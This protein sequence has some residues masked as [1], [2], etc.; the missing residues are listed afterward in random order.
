MPSL[1]TIFLFVRSVGLGK[2]VNILRYSRLLNRLDSAY[3]KAIHLSS[4]Q[5]PGNLTGFSQQANT[6][7]LH[8]DHADLEI[9]ILASNLARLTWQPGALP[10]PYAIAASNWPTTIPSLENTPDGLVVR[11]PELQ[12][13]VLAGGALTFLDAQ[14][15]RLRSERPP[16]YQSALPG[17]PSLGQTQWTSRAAFDGEECL[18]G[19]GEHTGPLSLAGQSHLLWNSD[20][21]GSHGPQT[22]PLYMPLPVYLALCP[23][24]GYLLFFENSFRAEFN[25]ASR[26]NPDEVTASFAGGALRYYLIAG[27][28]ARALTTFSQLT[29]RPALPPSWS[30]GYHQSRWG[31]TCEEDIRAVVAS[32][33]KHD[34]P[35]SA[36]HLDIDYMRGYRVFTIDPQRFPDL[37]SLAGELHKRDVRL[38]AITNPG[39]KV[40]PDYPLYQQGLAQGSFITLPGGRP[41]TGVVWPGDTAFP[42]FSNSEARQWWGQQYAHLFNSGIDG[43]WHDMN[44][45]ASFSTAG[46]AT[47]PF[48]ARSHMEG[49]GGDH[50]ESHN[51]YGLLMNRA[52]FEGLQTLYPER[53]PWIFSRS[54]WVSQ[55]RY[56]WVWTGDVETS[57][58]GL[59][60]TVATLISLGL[61]GI[62]FVGSDIGGFTGNPSAELYLRWFQMAAFTAL[63]RTHSAIGV[64]EREP[65]V[66]DELHTSLIRD[67]LRLRQ[68]LLPYLYTLSWQ[69]SQTGWPLVRP[70]F[71]DNPQD[72]R[73]WCVEDTFLLGDALLVAPILYSAET[74]RKIKLPAGA[75]FDFWDESC[76][77]GPAD[78]ERPAY[79]ERIPLLVR[80]HSLLPLAEGDQL[81]LHLYTTG[82][83]LPAS[84]TLCGQIY[85]DAGDGYAESRLD[86]FTLHAAPL[87]LHCTWRAEGDYPFPYQTIILKIHGV[88]LKTAEV[89]G[90]PIKE[91]AELSFSRPF[92]DLFLEVHS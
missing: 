72:Q 40:D 16:T 38:V 29:G 19:L 24:G 15:H 51:L 71:W 83:D 18:V 20:P 49:A 36:I 57:W 65:W 30:L 14:G 70:L 13:H 64:A 50:L 42:D 39:V 78:I 27:D 2:A 55:A 22:D 84:P 6:L 91:K 28:P 62:P 53:R 74:A 46:G 21:G 88:N 1:F 63:F 54:G 43:V 69:A 23:A 85:S 8:Y 11:T 17:S 33:I 73:L 61:S 81:T 32:F 9:A 48:S 68:R 58:E 77:E 79:L 44:E 25:F 92:H 35:L 47:L 12:I 66:F 75:W 80:N 56:A 90:T 5:L 89:D 7:H 3:E 59:R 10:I 76:L 52:A 31:Y 82:R 34:L 86:Q 37:P 41:L 60:Q 45:P 4:P 26:P 87:G 67:F